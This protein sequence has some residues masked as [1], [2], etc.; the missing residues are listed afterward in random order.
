MTDDHQTSHHASFIARSVVNYRP[1]RETGLMDMSPHTHA[2]THQRSKLTKFLVENFV[3]RHF[4]DLC[5]V[6]VHYAPHTEINQTV[7]K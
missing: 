4:S 6:L 2:Q 5:K 7:N 3:K 1:E